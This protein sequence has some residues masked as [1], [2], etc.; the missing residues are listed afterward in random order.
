M[1]LLLFSVLYILL[2]DLLLQGFVLI[3]SLDR[4]FVN[5]VGQERRMFTILMDLIPLGWKDFQ[6][7]FNSV[8]YLK[9]DKLSRTR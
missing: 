2:L 1:W 9:D 5:G 3:L 7:A 8:Q 6:V 4:T